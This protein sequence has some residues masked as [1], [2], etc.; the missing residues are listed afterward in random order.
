MILSSATIT[1]KPSV[2]V[3]S[4]LDYMENVFLPTMLDSEEGSKSICAMWKVEA[5]NQI[6]LFEVTTADAWVEL[7]KRIAQPEVKAKLMEGTILQESFSGK[8]YGDVSAE[9][10]STFQEWNA[11]P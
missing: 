4:W 10:E 1:L 7:Q 9:M 11:M 2:H 8:F 6:S 5:A 3:Q